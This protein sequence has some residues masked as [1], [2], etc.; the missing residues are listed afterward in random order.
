MPPSIQSIYPSNT[1]T[2]VPLGI[3]ILITFDMEIDPERAKKNIIITGPDFDQTSG[4][5][6]VLW[7]DVEKG[8]NPYFL[9]SPGFNGDLQG[10]FYFELLN[11]DNT[12][13]SGLDY[14]TGSPNYR[15]RVKF[16]PDKPLAPETTYTVYVIGDPDADDDIRR[17]IS[18]RT[19]YSTQFGANTGSGNVVFRGGYTGSIDDQIVVS[20]T[21]AGN[22]RDAEYEWW[23]ASIPEIVYTG[24]TS[25]KYRS[26]TGSGVELRFTG[27]DFAVGDTFT[28]NVYPPEY[29]TESYTYTFT[30]GT[31]SIQEIP[32]TTSTSVLGDVS[33]S[34]TLDEFTVVST[35]PEHKEVKVSPNVRLI[36][37]TFSADVDPTTIND[38]TVKVVVH[39]ATGYDPNVTDIGR[40]NKFLFIDSRTLFILLQTG[41]E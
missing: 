16:V 7:V 30:T 5:D 41:E 14:H 35:T 6:S 33:S 17:G 10:K 24:I 28:V 12:I 32:D 19:V 15:T 21:S 36:K 8:R 18:R 13:F 25:T 26:L 23:F 34:T 31:G 38:R 40:I 3:D 11:T 27:S 20:I 37:I 39:P 1:A 4:P 9:Q 29:M 2:G 22:I